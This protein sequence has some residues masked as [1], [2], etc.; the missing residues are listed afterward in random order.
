MS[1]IFLCC[2]NLT[3]QLI[4]FHKL[5]NNFLQEFFFINIIY[6]YFFVLLILIE[7]KLNADY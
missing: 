2:I 5:N 4:L 6:I 3:H 7:L 1:F